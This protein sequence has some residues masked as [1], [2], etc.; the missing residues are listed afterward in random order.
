MNKI[1]SWFI[2]S[3]YFFQ[4]ETFPTGKGGGS[5]NSPLSY[6]P[7]TALAGVIET[8]AIAG[9]RFFCR[10]SCKLHSIS[11]DTAFPGPESI[12]QSQ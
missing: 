1:A 11:I 8:V 4:D 6:K 12:P 9:R 5:W 10:A 2:L 7:H 3:G